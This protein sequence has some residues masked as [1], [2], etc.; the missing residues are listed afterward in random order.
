MFA[1]IRTYEG[2]GNIEVI[3]LPAKEQFFQLFEKLPGFVRIR[4]STLPA[5]Q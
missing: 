5:R 1:M 2:V 3:A 4:S